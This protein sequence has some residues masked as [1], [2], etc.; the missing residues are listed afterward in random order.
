MVTESQTVVNIKIRILM[1]PAIRN[2]ILHCT[3]VIERSIRGRTLMSRINS[4]TVN[5]VFSGKT[6]RPVK[7]AKT[8]VSAKL[9]VACT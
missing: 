9:V 5:D 3:W 8:V 1:S 2:F 6:V 7:S 4:G